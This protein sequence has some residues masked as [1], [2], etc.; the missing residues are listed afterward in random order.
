MVRRHIEQARDYYAREGLPGLLRALG[1]GIPEGF[2]QN[3]GWQYG[4]TLAS[5]AIYFLFTYVVAQALGVERFGLIALGM[6]VAAF[7]CQFINLRQREMT[8]RY[9]ARFQEEQ[10][11]PRMLATVKLSLLLDAACGAVALLALLAVAPWAAGHVL[12]A[13][14]GLA[15]VLVAGLAYV[16]QN[17]SDDTALGLLRVFGRFRL[18]AAMDVASA[19]L[20]LAG[21]LVAVHLFHGGVLAVLAV[22]AGT[23]LLVNATLLTRALADLRRRVPLAAHAP[24]ALLGPH[25]A[26]IVRFLKHNYLATL[27]GSA[28]VELDV[29]LLGYFG[30]KETAGVYKLAKSGA[31]ALAQGADAVF[32]VVYP[33]LARLWARA[34][35][36]RLKGFAKRLSLVLGGVGVVMYG[37]AFFL[38][39]FAILKLM[40]PEYA[41]AG[42]IFRCMAWG[43]MLWTPG[44][45]VAPLIVAAGRTDIMLKAAVICGIASA[46]GYVGAIWLGGVYGAAVMY[47]LSVPLWMIVIIGY[48]R[49]AGILF[50]EQDAAGAR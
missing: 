38:V 11:Y 42:N 35:Y 26:E 25:R 2:F 27:A 22:L 10:D 8:I 3:V 46:L 6:G 30:A 37:L 13:D 47:A 23:H 12:K 32:L 17:V 19:C 39:P 18:L 31:V 43:V 48:G 34:D 50:P 9:I 16:I 15:V 28:S 20:K 5:T 45:W 36:A 40:K 29:N 21:A 49:R 41:E 33:E 44:I 4:G 7:V 14:N 1:Q 24:L